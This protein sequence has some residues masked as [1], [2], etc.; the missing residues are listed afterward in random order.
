MVIKIDDKPINFY[1]CI[2]L[3][4]AVLILTA[5]NNGRLVNWKF[6]ES[7][8]LHFNSLYDVPVQQAGGIILL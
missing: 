8:V 5:M 2:K 7:D 4:T 1:N 3:G 6:V